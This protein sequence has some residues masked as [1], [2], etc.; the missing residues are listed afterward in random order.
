MKIFYDQDCRPQFLAGKK[1]AIIGYGSQGHAH[2]NN[3]KDAGHRVMVGLRTDSQSWRKAQ[4]AG[5]E[6]TSTAE[7]TDRG[8]AV[9]MGIPDET[10]PAIS[11]TQ[12]APVLR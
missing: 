7:A 9:M 1:I 2:A 11:K 6:G 8:D 3:L 12:I 10:E 5:L 4:T